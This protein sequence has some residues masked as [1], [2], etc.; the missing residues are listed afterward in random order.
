MVFCCN[1]L[2]PVLER[3]RPTKVSTEIVGKCKLSDTRDWGFP[4]KSWFVARPKSTTRAGESLKSLWQTTLG[5]VKELKSW[6]H[7]QINNLT[8]LQTKIHNKSFFSFQ[9]S[10]SKRKLNCI[11]RKPQKINLGY[12][13]FFLNSRWH[14]FKPIF[15]VLLFLFFRPRTKL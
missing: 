9:V 10:Q 5:K 1:H 11:E 6:R 4:A 2:L 12:L 14:L 15:F 8:D 3:K 7:A 13:F